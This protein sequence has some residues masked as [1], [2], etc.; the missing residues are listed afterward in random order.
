MAKKTLADIMSER[1]RKKEGQMEIVYREV[2]SLLPSEENFYSTKKL[3]DLK[4]SIALFG[5]LQ[6]ILIQQEDGKDI[7][8]AGHRRRLAVL[9]L[10]EEGYENLRKV[11]CIYI[12]EDLSESSTE[13]I[14]QQMILIQAN[15]FREKTEWEKMTEVIQ[16]EELVKE[17]R[18]SEK[19]P[20]KTRDLLAQVTGIK[21]TKLARYHKIAANLKPE[22][23]EEFK[24]GRISVSV[25]DAAAGLPPSYQQ[26]AW[27]KL[28]E[29][30]ILEIRDIETLA[31]LQRTEEEVEGQISLE[32]ILP[33]PDLP[34]N[35]AEREDSQNP[36][37]EESQTLRKAQ[38]EMEKSC[39]TSHT[40]EKVS[41]LDTFNTG[42]CIHQKHGDWNIWDVKKM[43]WKEEDTL[44]CCREDKELSKTPLA[45]ES[46]ITVTALRLLLERMQEE[47][48]ED[49]K[50][51]HF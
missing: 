25:A 10:I 49:T 24:A 9:E 12:Q 28:L 37:A 40:E 23:M 8:K 21:S 47:Q 5:I 31:V 11:P 33:A 14:V 7:V 13:T 36:S 39:A 2:S 38:Q 30:G 27:E 18:K 50:V 43:L 22:L 44:K 35:R 16:M 51:P 20:G 17:L 6:P 1:A 45:K 4:Q 48:N 34:Q 26:Q 15:R 19:I 3:E 29:Q 41:D 46:E 42:E 32:D